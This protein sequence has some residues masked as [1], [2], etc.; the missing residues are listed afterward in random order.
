M[1]TFTIAQAARHLGLSDQGVRKM[2]G[3]QELFVLPGSAPARLSAEHVETVRL[4]RRESIL[5]ELARRSRTPVDLARETRRILQPSATLP[6][7][8]AA[9]QRLRLSLV[10]PDARQLFGVASLTAACAEGGCRWCLAAAFARTLGGWAPEYSAGFA[11]LFGQEP[12]EV[13]SAG[14][15]GPVMAA[16][17]ARVHSGGRRPSGPAPRPTEADRVRAR[18]W[19]LQRPVTASARPGQVDDGKVLV[20]RRLRQVRER[21]KAAVRRGDT[22]YA[23]QL[24]AMARGL[25][26]DAARIDGRPSKRGAS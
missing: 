26:Q 23:A 9:E 1:E 5:H 24:S 8:R 18:E 17:A 19:A 3:R 14:L 2:L 22:E 20:A 25:E 21:R 13:C 7:H 10:S 16:L 4:L 6:D 11:V 15:Y 12:C